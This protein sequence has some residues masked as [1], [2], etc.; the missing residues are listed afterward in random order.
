MDYEY[1]LHWKFA[2]EWRLKKI[3]FQ[4]NSKLK[5]IED[6]IYLIEQKNETDRQQKR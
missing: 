3:S 5:A 4:E 1:Q 2:D 6:A